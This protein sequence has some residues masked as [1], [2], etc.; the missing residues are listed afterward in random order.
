MCCGAWS[1]PYNRGVQRGRLGKAED[2]YL[3]CNFNNLVLEYRKFLK[4]LLVSS[5]VVVNSI[6][7]CGMKYQEFGGD[8]GKDCALSGYILW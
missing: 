4:L 3:H 7:N 6:F 5:Y 2:I 8:K 1:E